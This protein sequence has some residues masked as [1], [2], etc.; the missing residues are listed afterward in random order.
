MVDPNFSPYKSLQNCTLDLTEQVYQFQKHQRSREFDQGI[1]K[2]TRLTY[3]HFCP[4]PKEQA[5]EILAFAAKNRGKELSLSRRSSVGSH[6]CYISLQEDGKIRYMDPNHGAYL[7]SSENDFID[8]F[9]A[10][11]KEDKQS[12]IDFR[13]YSLSELKYDPTKSQSELKTAEGVIRSLLSGSKYSDNSLMAKGVNYTLYAYAGLIPGAVIGGLIGSFLLPGIG[14]IAAAC[15]GGLVG[16][17]ATAGLVFYATLKGHSGLLAFPHLIQDTWHSIKEG[18]SEYF[19][20]STEVA[21]KTETSPEKQKSDPLAILKTRPDCSKAQ[22]ATCNQTSNAAGENEMRFS[23]TGLI[24]QISN[25]ALS[26]VVSNHK[27]DLCSDASPEEPGDNNE[28]RP[29]F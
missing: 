28:V 23:S 14:T 20:P 13:F 22:A 27:K 11:S 26:E 19:F 7:F 9:I 4:N 21:V 18:F 5:Y 10:A 6:A 1:V 8:F 25:S 3:E 17:I 16:G 24:R 29:R 12:G 2:K 15:I